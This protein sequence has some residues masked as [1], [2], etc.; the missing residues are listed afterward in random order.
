MRSTETL[1]P[2]LFAAYGLAAK[3]DEHRLIAQWGQIVGPQ[4]AL[5]TT[6]REIRGRTLWV[7]VDSSTWLHELTLLK[8]LLL[9]KLVPVAGKAAVQDVRFVIDEVPAPE[10]PPERRLP[11]STVLDPEAEAALDRAVSVIAD[12]ELRES[13]RRL[14]RKAGASSP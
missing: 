10:S 11:Q 14:L 12:A 3:L 9:E 5:H 13:A 8:P 4:I 6:P 7:V 1:I 2:S